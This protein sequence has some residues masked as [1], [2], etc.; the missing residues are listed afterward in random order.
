MKNK[1]IKLNAHVHSKVSPDAIITMNDLEQIF[2]NKVLDQIA[3]TDHDKINFAKK[4]QKKFGP[5][6]II[7]GQ[8]IT[9]NKNKHII[10]LFI[11]KFITK[12]LS[13]K[14][15]C[16][17]I[18]NQGGVVLIPHPFNGNY[19][20][21]QNE[22]NELNE[23]VKLNLIDIIESFNAWEQFTIANIK[24]RKKNNKVAQEFS[25]KNNL[26]SLSNSD[27]HALSDLYSTYTQ[28]PD[29]L[30]QD[31]YK[32]LLKNSDIVF[33]NQYN[34]VKF[35]NIKAGFKM[36]KSKIKNFPIL[37]RFISN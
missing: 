32:K 1:K 13:A 19:G 18:R 2:K 31:N 37:N 26:L 15:T 24:A 20:L 28:L 7:I 3:I 35:D 17:L 25:K 10:A 34:Q 6:K 30:T 29:Y 5:K 8:E 36:Y 4:A 14:R 16:Q 23:L 27:A 12:G 21:G 11:N 22:L 9:T 33:H